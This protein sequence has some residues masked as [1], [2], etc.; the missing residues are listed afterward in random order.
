MTLLAQEVR[1]TQN[2]GLGAAIMWRFACGYSSEHT[3]HAFAPLQL[4][5][6][7]LP[8][9]FHRPLLD[10]ID[11]TQRASGLRQFVMKLGDTKEARQDLLFAIQDRAEKWKDVSLESLRIAL[12]CRLVRLELDGRLIPLTHTEPS[13]VPPPAKRMLKNGEKLG[14]WMSRLSLHEISNMLHVRF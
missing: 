8:I 3:E 14:A 7:A 1:A 5:F 11:G 12:A 4:N 6:L 2:P 10:L 9:I 13:G